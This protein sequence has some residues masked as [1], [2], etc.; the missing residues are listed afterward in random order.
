MLIKILLHFHYW[1]STATSWNFFKWSFFKSQVTG[2]PVFQSPLDPYFFVNSCKQITSYWSPLFSGWKFVARPLDLRNITLKSQI[3]RQWEESNTCIEEPHQ[4]LKA[5]PDDLLQK[6]T[7]HFCRDHVQSCLSSPFQHMEKVVQ[8][9]PPQHQHPPGVTKPCIHIT[10]DW[11]KN[12]TR[13][14][15]ECLNVR[16]SFKL[17]QTELVCSPSSNHR[18]WNQ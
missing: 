9:Q 16:C 2:S 6:L 8:L 17:H 10:S 12:A 15:P 11:V 7:R 3:D 5:F 4:L 13:Y 18:F 1:Q 14:T